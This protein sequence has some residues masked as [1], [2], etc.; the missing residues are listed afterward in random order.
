MLDLG[1][2]GVG[3]YPGAGYKAAKRGKADDWKCCPTPQPSLSKALQAFLFLQ[4][5]YENPKSKAGSVTVMETGFIKPDD[6]ILDAGA[7]H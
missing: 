7:T 3:F 5:R 1:G 6:E 2:Y 4:T